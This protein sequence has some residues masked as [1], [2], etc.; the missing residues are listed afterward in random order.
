[1]KDFWNERYGEEGLAYGETPNEYLTTVVSNIPSGG[2]VLVVGDGEGRNGVWLAEQGF[3]VLSIDYS[4]VAIEK[5]NALANKRN[6]KIVAEC[7][8][9]T[10]YHWPENQFDAV[11]AIYVHFPPGVR[12]QM[13]SKMVSSLK[14]GGKVIMEAFH[15]AQLNYSSGGPP[16]EPM[17]FSE[18]MLKDDFSQAKIIEL[19]ETIAP[20]N[21]GK[22]HVGDGAVVRLIAEKV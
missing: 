8:D 9:L 17:L 19:Y 22:Y 2:S 3:N 7:H 18:A 20:L 13:H 4:A 16:V 6:V 11:V 1:M 14:T 10:E 21:E 15:K 5:I 12:E